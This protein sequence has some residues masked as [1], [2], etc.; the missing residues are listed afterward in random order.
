MMETKPKFSKHN[1]LAMFPPSGERKKNTS[2]FNGL[3]TTISSSFDLV[4]SLSS[5]DDCHIQTP[6]QQKQKVVDLSDTKREKETESLE[7]P[8]SN[9]VLPLEPLPLQ[10]LVLPSVTKLQPRI[11]SD[12][13]LPQVPP[14]T[15]ISVSKKKNKR[16]NRMKKRSIDL[17]GNKNHVSTATSN[18]WHNIT[19]SIVEEMAPDG[20]LDPN[21]ILRHRR[22]SKLFPPH[23]KINRM[24]R[25]EKKTNNI[26]G[27]KRLFKSSKKSMSE[28]VLENYL[29]SDIG[30][31]AED[32][33]RLGRTLHPSSSSSPSSFLNFESSDDKHEERENRSPD[34]SCFEP[35]A[36]GIERELPKS[37]LRVKTKDGPQQEL[38]PF[39][40]KQAT[41]QSVHWDETQLANKVEKGILVGVSSSRRK[42][43][44]IRV[45]K[46]HMLE[47]IAIQNGYGVG[48]TS[49]SEQDGNRLGFGRN[50]TSQGYIC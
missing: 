34:P 21:N 25:N 36:A 37:I 35:K 22:Q 43:R 41:T 48:E 45:L 1:N 16:R 6:P 9:F 7:F 12:E 28:T 18:D 39:T 20:P 24:M 46:K 29:P 19:S 33:L 17:G 50:N 40:F 4:A 49:T 27:K 31:R 47:I 32:S 30:A 26:A 14:S 13:L 10:K 44:P 5:S 42:C 15:A 2:E 11:L 23:L 3:S 38:F 8:S